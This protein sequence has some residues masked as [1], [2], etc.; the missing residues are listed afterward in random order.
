M[1]KFGKNIFYTNGPSGKDLNILMFQ[2]KILV[3]KDFNN[4]RSFRI[5]FGVGTVEVK[6]YAILVN[7]CKP[8]FIETINLSKGVTIPDLKELTYYEIDL[9][10]CYLS[11]RTIFEYELD[12]TPATIHYS[13]AST[14]GSN[15][16]ESDKY[17]F[18]CFCDSEGG[19][20]K[21]HIVLR[22]DKSTKVVSSKTITTTDANYGTYHKLPSM[23][24]TSAGTLL[25]VIQQLRGTSGNSPFDC[26]RWTD[27]DDLETY[28]Q[29]TANLTAWG[30]YNFIFEINDK[31]YIDFRGSSGTGFVPEKKSVYE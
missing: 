13:G 31:I 10:K 9:L 8:S 7:Q 22:Y 2:I 30:A 18:L 25:I 24:I 23:L 20:Y 1:N 19:D 21:N 3:K 6:V 11:N 27:L 12:F 28:S 15:I 5:T 4:Q 29:I 17:I 16:V 26:F 14:Y